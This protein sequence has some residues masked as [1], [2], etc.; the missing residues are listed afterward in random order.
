MEVWLQELTNVLGKL[1]MQPLLYWFFIF[2]I[3]ISMKRI[4][5]ERSMFGIRVFDIFSE[6]KGTWKTGFVAGGILSVVMVGAGIVIPYPVIL[7]ISTVI[8]LV[9]LSMRLRFLSAAYTFAISYGLFFLLQRLPVTIM[10]DRWQEML[11]AVSLSGVGVILAVL[12]FVEAFWMLR[13]SHKETFPELVAGSRGKWIGQH[14]LK[15][16]GLIPFFV[17]IPGGVITSFMPWWPLL[18]IAGNGYGLMLVP[19]M[20]GFE[21]KSK[22]QHPVAAAKKLGSGLFLLAL[23]V[24]GL[25]L[26]SYWWEWLAFVS[27]GVAVIGKVFVTMLHHF[28]DNKRTYFSAND[29]G[30][31]VL[32]VIKNS[33]AAQMGV[34][35]GD[36]IERINQRKVTNEEEFY[37]ALQVNRALCKIEVRDRRGEIRFT[38][39]AMYE[40]DPHQLGLLFVKENVRRKAASH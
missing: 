39:R 19:L 21:V 32:G 20:T 29:D 2:G 14:R 28:R 10:P 36:Q 37:Y 31:K 24:S 5:I 6:L 35:V 22:G 34:E 33:P 9:S 11:G 17:L 40:N 26:A 1:L 7:L 4:T 13:L 23:M 18:D 16:L 3:I 25:I 30:L 38:Q 12:L 15:K 8:L 27:I